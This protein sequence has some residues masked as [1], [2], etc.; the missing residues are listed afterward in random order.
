MFIF[1][2]L[3]MLISIAMAG[4]IIFHII[5]RLSDIKDMYEA[6]ETKLLAKKEKL[7]SLLLIIPCILFGVCLS[8]QEVPTNSV[9]ILYSRINGT[10]E[11]TLS[12]G[13]HFTLPLLEKVYTIDTTV[14]ERTIT[15]ISIQTKDSQY[16]TVEINVKYR[17]NSTNAYLVYK[18]YGSLDNLGENIISNYSQKALET[19]I[20][21]YAIIDTLGSYKNEIYEKATEVLSVMLA[22]E[23]VE[24][25]Q[26]TIKDMDAGEAIES[27]IQAE[28]V[29]AKEVE[30]AQQELLKAEIEAETLLVQA[31]AEADANEVLTEM[32]TDEIL[33]K[34]FIEKWD[35]VLPVVVSDSSNILDISS[36]ISE[37]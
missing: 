29:A 4:G 26:L 23:G 9:G 17:V 37:E 24:L 28:A 7:K 20:T 5:Q 8:I 27:A 33:E 12:E 19:V 15:G 13:I 22:E 14:Q 2:M 18:G 3:V 11:T 30:T 21:E 16:L 25:V 36:L 1:K 34:M 10:S 32:L 35:G 6:K 31:Q